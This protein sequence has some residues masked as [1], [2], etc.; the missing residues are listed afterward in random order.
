M[1]G[2]PQWCV[3]A[4]SEILEADPCMCKGNHGEKV[5]HLG[6]QYAAIIDKHA[7]GA[8]P[9]LSMAAVSEKLENREDLLHAALS[10]IRRELQGY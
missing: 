2:V 1:D 7:V 9:G 8:S 10:F 5:E 6:T 3:D 4:A